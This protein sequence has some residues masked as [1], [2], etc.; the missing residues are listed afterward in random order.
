M[1]E[2]TGPTKDSVVEQLNKVLAENKPNLGKALHYNS[3][4]LEKRVLAYIAEVK[5]ADKLTPELIAGAK[6]FKV[7]VLVK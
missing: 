6:A 5:K 7:P 2:Q 1:A 4:L 3:Y